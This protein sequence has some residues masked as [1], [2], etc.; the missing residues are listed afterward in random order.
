MGKAADVC[1]GVGGCGVGVRGGR[2]AVSRVHYWGLGLFRFRR[3]GAT[4]YVNAE[5]LCVALFCVDSYVDI[6]MIYWEGCVHFT[7]RVPAAL[8]RILQYYLVEMSDFA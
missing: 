1:K 8:M 3:L 2:V 5:N 4:I 7:K 6:C